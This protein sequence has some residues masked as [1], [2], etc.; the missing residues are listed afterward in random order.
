MGYKSLT[1][2]ELLRVH[3][4]HVYFNTA[5][6]E[7]VFTYNPKFSRTKELLNYFPETDQDRI[8]NADTKLL[9]RLLAELRIA[10]LDHDGM[11]TR[12]DKAYRKWAVR[13]LEDMKRFDALDLRAL[14]DGQLRAEFDSMEKSHLKHY[15]LIR[16][17]MVTH[18]IGTNLMVKRW[19]TDWLDDRSACCTPSSSQGSRTTRPSETNIALAKLREAR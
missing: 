16:Y 6:L 12:T 9:R 4:G 14:D 17:G 15:R 18:S 10:V 5:V 8:A 7:E 1:D 2:R 11:I 19:L 13:F 3:K